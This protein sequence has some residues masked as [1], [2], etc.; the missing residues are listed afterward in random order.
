MQ[1]ETYIDI[2]AEIPSVSG[3]KPVLAVLKTT[4]SYAVYL[5]ALQIRNGNV[6]AILSNRSSIS[7]SYNFECT[8]LYL[9]NYAD[10]Y[11]V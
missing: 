7:A 2:T 4:G 10:A 6:V 3:Y 1:P 9:K 8:V 11:T 5:L